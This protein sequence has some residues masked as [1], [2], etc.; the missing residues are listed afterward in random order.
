M[1]PSLRERSQRSS[2]DAIS[3]EGE[4]IESTDKGPTERG[5]SV[6]GVDIDRD[7]YHRPAA[8]E[9]KDCVAPSSFRNQIARDSHRC[10]EFSANNGPH[11]FDMLL[12]TNEGE[13]DV[14]LNLSSDVGETGESEILCPRFLAECEL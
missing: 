1:S 11:P 7:P 4:T 8:W 2:Q 14:L 9:L 3:I 5:R 6:R 13:F 12:S 10:G